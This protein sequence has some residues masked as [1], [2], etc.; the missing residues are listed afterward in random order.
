M[1]T[2]ARL[3]SSGSWVSGWSTLEYVATADTARVSSRAYGAADWARCCALMIR[4]AAMS[5]I[6]RVIFFIDSVDLIRARYSRTERAM[7]SAP[8][9][10][11]DLL[12]LDVLVLEGDVLFLAGLDAL[13]VGGLELVE[14]G[15]VGRGELVLGGVLELQALADAGED[16][17]VAATQVVEELVLEA[18]DVVGRDLVEAAR[19]AGPQGDGHLLDRVRRVL[20]L[21]EQRH[22]ALTAVELLARGRVEVRG[23]HREGLHGAELR[24]VDLE[25]AGDGLHRLRH[26]RTTHARDR[27][28]HVDGG[29][30]VG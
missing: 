22:Q 18:Q 1:S 27:D 3:D 30:L 9:L 28:T 21:L 11:D 4:D 2:A 14:E 15:V 25:R 5:S 19:R 6:A 16:A 10:L 7:A 8:L 26:R 20:R 13:A 12:L 17:L 23:E 29:T 24:Q